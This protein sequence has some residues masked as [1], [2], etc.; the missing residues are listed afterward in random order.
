MSKFEKVLPNTQGDGI[1]DKLVSFKKLLLHCGTFAQFGRRLDP[2][3][4][5]VSTTGLII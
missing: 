4:I 3:E 5:S 1:L 2:E